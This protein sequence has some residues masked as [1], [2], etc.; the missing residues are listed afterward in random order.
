MKL[1][2]QNH[3]HVYSFNGMLRKQT[4]GGPI[5]LELTGD[6]AQ[7]FMNWWDKKMKIKMIEENITVLI[8]KR[9]VDDINIAATYKGYN[10]RQPA[11][12]E[13]KMMNKIKQIGNSIHP[14]IHL[15]MNCPPLHDDNKLPMLDILSYY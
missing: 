6:V 3:I 1:I 10:Q 5:G 4:K 13:K 2:M 8:Y 7:I 11:E 14:S 12:E 15:E 9:Y